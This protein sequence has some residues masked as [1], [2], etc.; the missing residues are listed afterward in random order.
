MVLLLLKNDL[1]PLVSDNKPFEII[2]PNDRYDKSINNNNFPNLINLKNFLLNIKKQSLAAR[3]VLCSKII[4]AVREFHEFYAPLPPPPVSALPPVSVS[5]EPSPT[6][7]MARRNRNNLTV[8]T[9]KNLPTPE[10]ATSFRSHSFTSFVDTTTTN[11]ST[12]SKQ[13]INLTLPRVYGSLHPCRFVLLEGL[14]SGSWQ[15]IVPTGPDVLWTGSHLPIASELGPT[16]YQAPEVALGFETFA[17]KE[18]DIFA[19]GT[20]L[21]EIMTGHPLFISDEVAIKAYLDINNLEHK[22]AESLQVST[23]PETFINKYVR[24]RLNEV[25]M[26]DKLTRDLMYRMLQWQPLARPTYA[27]ITSHPLFFQL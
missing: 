6:T 14:F 17:C 1:Y 19:L 20:I 3:S 8:N 13:N 2:D 12:I 23:A 11:S 26:E 5:V 16:R 7:L 27:K 18:Q 24:G 25:R 21:F 10:S 15:F 22:Q 9:F 4:A